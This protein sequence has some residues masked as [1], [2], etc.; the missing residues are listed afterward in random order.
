MFDNI[1]F[2]GIR[3]KLGLSKV[4]NPKTTDWLVD[5]PESRTNILL[6]KPPDVKT[7]D[8]L[9]GQVKRK[10]K[11][12]TSEYRESGL[13]PIVDQ[14]KEFIAGYTDDKE[15]IHDEDLIVFGDHTR[16]FKYCNF[17]F[18][19]GADGT[20]LLKPNDVERMPQILLYFVGCSTGEEVLSAAGLLYEV[21]LEKSIKDWRKWDI[22]LVGLEPADYNI[23]IAL[24]K[25]YKVSYTGPDKLRDFLELD[26]FGRER[27]TG[28]SVHD[29]IE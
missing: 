17:P 15:T 22:C 1:V 8:S 4:F 24:K 16:C 27:A 23:Q 5:E 28:A 29:R 20:Q 2:E 9:L 11:I 25:I 6:L 19:C 13:Y 18:A 12:Q 3:S 14:G 21:L 10:K 26:G 7:I